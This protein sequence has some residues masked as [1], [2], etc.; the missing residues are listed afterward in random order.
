MNMPN[1]EKQATVLEKIAPLIDF[2]G[3]ANSFACNPLEY[4]PAKGTILDSAKLSG[5]KRQKSS[6][7]SSPSNP[8]QNNSSNGQL[9][10]VRRKLET[11]QSKACI[12]N[13][14]CADSPC[15]RNYVKDHSIEKNFPR[16]QVTVVS[17]QLFSPTSRKTSPGGLEQLLSSKH[18]GDL[19]TTPPVNKATILPALPASEILG[20]GK[21]HLKE[22]FIRLQ[23]FLKNSNQCNQDEY[24]QKLR[25]LSA[26]GRSM[27]AFELEKRAIQL[28]LDEGRELQRMKALN[29]LGKPLP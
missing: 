28:L 26:T 4:S 18:P 10:Y 6:S 27:H 21:E 5:I 22:R 29:V 20:Q 9:V 1:I 13:E 24:V 2:S 25:S 3:E 11:E 19:V 16:E 14:G 12:E 23:M 15:S 7:P 17:S 8:I